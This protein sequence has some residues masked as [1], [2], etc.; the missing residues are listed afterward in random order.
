MY[1]CVCVCVCVCCVERCSRELV[2]LYSMIPIPTESIVRL[3]SIS[4][5]GVRGVF[6]GIGFGMCVFVCVLLFICNLI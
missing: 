1:C 5:G 2:W 6:V 4:E 3:E